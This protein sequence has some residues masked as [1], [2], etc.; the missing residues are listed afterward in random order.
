MRISAL[1]VAGVTEIKHSK[2]HAVHCDCGE[3][4][5]YRVRITLISSTGHRLRDHLDLCPA[6]YELFLHVESHANA[7]AEPAN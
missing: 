4:A 1:P 2:H 7:P 5:R 3:L 6:C